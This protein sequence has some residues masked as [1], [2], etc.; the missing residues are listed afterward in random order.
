MPGIETF[1]Q[2]KFDG[3]DCHVFADFPVSSALWTSRYPF[4]VSYFNFL[5]SQLS[6][7]AVCLAPVHYSG[8]LNATGDLAVSSGNGGGSFFHRFEPVIKH[9]A[10]VRHP[11]VVVG[12]RRRAGL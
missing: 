12:S 3:V 11:V 7:N 2:V 1:K 8:T 5:G 10:A 6:E 4:I 9:G